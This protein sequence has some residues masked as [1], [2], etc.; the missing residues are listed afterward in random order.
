M[1]LLGTI[2]L[3]SLL[4]F[5]C[6]KTIK[7]TWVLI[8]TYVQISLVS[9]YNTTSIIKACFVSTALT[10]LTLLY[11]SFINIADIGD[12]RPC[13]EAWCTPVPLSPSCFFKTHCTV[14]T[15]PG[16]YGRAS[17]QPCHSQSHRVHP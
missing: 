14:G 2:R 15:H 12:N 6:R 13:V 10:V 9:L 8:K 3:V 16:I 1:S 4:G 7:T 17:P 11:C 5:S